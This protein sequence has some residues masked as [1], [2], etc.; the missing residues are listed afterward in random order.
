MVRAERRAIA[1]FGAVNTDWFTI[2]GGDGF[3]T[4]QDPT[5]W[6]IVYAESQDGSDEPRYD[7]GDG[8][9]TSIRPN[10][11]RR[12]RRRRRAPAAAGG[13]PA[14]RAGGGGRRPGKPDAVRSERGGGGGNI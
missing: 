5:D 2:G 13:A 8:T 9:S 11:G 4:R 3:Y 10:V 1:Q 7:S 14:R 6:A 12:T